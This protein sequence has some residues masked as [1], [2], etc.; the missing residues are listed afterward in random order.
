LHYG[1]ITW[2]FKKNL[3]FV[4]FLKI[5]SKQ[6]HDEIITGRRHWSRS[7]ELSRKSSRGPK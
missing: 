1:R 4:A 6:E 7:R 3:N 2:G 5:Y